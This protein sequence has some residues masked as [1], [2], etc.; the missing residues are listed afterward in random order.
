MWTLVVTVAEPGFLPEPYPPTWPQP[1]AYQLPPTSFLPAMPEPTLLSIGDIAVTR[2]SVVLP[3]GRFALRGSTW[4]VQDSSTV[5]TTIPA[6]AIVLA[7]V[8]FFFCL[9]GLLFLLIK[10]TKYWGF[11]SVTVVGDGFYH[12]VQLPPGPE[13][14]GW[15]AHQVGQARA[16]AAMA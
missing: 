10:E 3:Q 5:T 2:T 7:I 15:V 8:F 13:M 11:I 16:L 4:T 6:Y 9:L 14:P 12:T 1:E